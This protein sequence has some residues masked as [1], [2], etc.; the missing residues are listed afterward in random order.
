VLTYE[1]PGGRSEHLTFGDLRERSAAFAGALAERG[2]ARADRVAMLLRNSPELFIW[3]ALRRKP[4]IART[5][6][7]IE[8]DGLHSRLRHRHTA[9]RQ[10]HRSAGHDAPPWPHA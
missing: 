7:P 10:R 2:I 8:V 3:L 9:R 1:G 6:A 5:T 4:A